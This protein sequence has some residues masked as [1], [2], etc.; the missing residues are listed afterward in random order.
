MPLEK[1]HVLMIYLAESLLMFQ[2]LKF[3]TCQY[4]ALQDFKPST[5]QHSKKIFPILV[6]LASLVYQMFVAI[7]QL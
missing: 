4:N 3:F 1:L 2:N 7:E 6:F 5:L